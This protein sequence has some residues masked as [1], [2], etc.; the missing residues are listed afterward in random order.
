MDQLT[1][2]LDR[3]WD[4]IQHGETQGAQDSARRALEIDPESPEAH[5]LLGYTAALQGD[6]E[7]ALDAYEQA[8]VLDDT[9][10]EAML[11]AAELY[12]HPLGE[13]DEVLGLCEQVLALSE[14]QDEILDALV[15]QF[16]ALLGKGDEAEAKKVLARVPPGPYEHA[17]Q[18]FL[19]ARAHYE[20]GDRET[21]AKLL[22]ATLALDANHADGWYYAGLVREEQGDRRGAIEALLR[23]REID[24]AGGMPPWTPSPETLKLLTEQALSALPPELGAHLQSAV[25]YIA[26][27]PGA[28]VVVDG[29][30]P[31]APALVEAV[32]Q[33]APG[34]E[35]TAAEVR[36]FVYA[37]NVVKAAGG[38]HA[39]EGQIRE[40]LAREIGAVFGAPAPEPPA[41]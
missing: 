14:Y 3:G 34:A 19:V 18:S 38:L 25:V 36:V 20:V 5:N 28:E 4:L 27:M 22:E 31:R 39:V 24:L 15:L 29:V 2:H 26:A 21:A 35:T 11:N 32:P 12:L 33:T 40:A 10:V 6:I 1:A 23:S 17:A 41:A 37:L 30:D 8:I 13:H 9:Y 16:E 7:D